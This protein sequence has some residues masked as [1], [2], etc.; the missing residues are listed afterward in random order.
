MAYLYEDKELVY[1]KQMASLKK[2]II[3]VNLTIFT[4]NFLATLIL[5]LNKLPFMDFITLVIPVFLLNLVISYAMLNNRDSNEQLYLAM[6]SSIIGT[7]VVIINIFLIEKNPATYMLIYL[8]IAIISVYKDKKAVGLGYAIIFFFGT[9]IHFN[10]TSALVGIN[11]VNNNLTPFLY[12]SI[13]IIVLLVQT[14]RTLYNEKEIDY[15]YEQ[16]EIQKEVELKYQST[17]YSFLQENHD[18]ISYTDEYAN[19]MNH[20]K[21][22]NYLELFNENFYLKGDI[23][24]K[25]NQYLDLQRYRSPKKILGKK[26]GGYK[27][28]KELSQFEDMSTYKLSKFMSLV[29]SITYRNQKNNK[30][31]NIKNFESLF[32][33][34]D[35]SIEVQIIGFILLY[36]HLRNEKPY[37]NNLSH[38]QILEHF[39]KR[40]SV[41][42]I[43]K[44]ILNFF[45]T[46]E[47]LFNDI[48]EN[49]TQIVE[50]EC[51]D[52]SKYL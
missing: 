1:E 36:E 13:L 47:Q 15:L 22:K 3:I 39:K 43:D 21:L 16:L 32:M 7:I 20:E 6:Y 23:Y 35:M 30:I 8:A 46:N 37:I 45:I 9:I 12:E 26:L 11:N 24:A 31:N 4:T 51:N 50:E 33:N 48:Y 34:P 19:E 40:E 17:F 28:K 42:V 41:E 10:H 38:D 2:R 29:T 52:E 18:L 14:I 5:L 27:L 49:T 25:L 44:E